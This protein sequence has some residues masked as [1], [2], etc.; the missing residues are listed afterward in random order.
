MAVAELDFTEMVV[1]TKLAFDAK[2]GSVVGWAM[3]A[4]PAYRAGSVTA[5]PS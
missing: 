5:S 3:A 2:L 4:V 1:A